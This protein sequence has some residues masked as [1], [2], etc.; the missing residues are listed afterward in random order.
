[1]ENIKAKKFLN[2]YLRRLFALLLLCFSLFSSFCAL[3]GCAKHPPITFSSILDIQA[4][5]SGTRTMSVCANKKTLQKLFNNNNFSFQSFITA[6]CPKLLE[7]NYVE[8]ASDY[9]I[10]FILYFSSLEDYQEKIAL[11]TGIDEFTTVSRPKVGVKTG[12]S[13]SEQDSVMSVFSWFTDALTQRTGLSNHEMSSY[14]LQQSNELIY[15][16]RNYDSKNGSL[17]CTAETILDASRIDILTSL[18]LNEWTREIYIIFPDEL[19]GNESNVKTYLDSMVPEQIISSWNDDVTWKLSFNA[20]SFEKLCILTSQLF[21]SSSHSSAK[22][23]ILA[24]NSMCIVHSYSEPFHFSFFVPDSGTTRARY[25]YRSDTKASIA[26][27]DE[28]YNLQKLPSERNGYSGYQCLF[29]DIVDKNCTYNYDAVFQYQPMQIT[30]DSQVQSIQLLT[31]TFSL[32]MGEIPQ[33][34]RNM[35]F[36]AI[37]ADA[38]GFGTVSQKTDADNLTISFTQTGTPSYL[39]KGFEA[40]FHKAESLD[41]RCE[42]TALFEPSHAYYFVDDMDFSEFLVDDDATFIFCKIKLPPSTSILKEQL[43][44][45][46]S[47]SP[48]ILE[49]TYSVQTSSYLLNIKMTLTQTNAAYYLCILA[50]LIIVAAILYYVY[51]YLY[52]RQET[53][54]SKTSVKKKHNRK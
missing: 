8:T 19:K 29:D 39:S 52:R 42:K 2:I 24:E 38:E 18:S 22:E 14:L 41:Y 1:M 13:L 44:S 45:N 54:A 51:V 12:F 30:I 4:D 32:S 53:N 15:N 49:D 10:T 33:L 28:K 47:E 16:G 50:L 35:I 27:Y 5:E 11:L 48:S 43:E 20:D 25:F 3:S 21:Q 46:L 26:V 9:E 40:V 7:W 17:S 23:T 36:D 37:S 34:H 31:R 6:N